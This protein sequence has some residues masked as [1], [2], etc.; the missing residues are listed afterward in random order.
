MTSDR[1]EDDFLLKN[2]CINCID[3]QKIQP[4]TKNTSMTSMQMLMTAWRQWM[5]YEFKCENERVQTI[6]AAVS[7]EREKEI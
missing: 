3:M 7:N 5:N 6:A 1:Q 4:Q 2:I